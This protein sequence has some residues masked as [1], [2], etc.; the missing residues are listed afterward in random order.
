MDV[1]VT[2]NA[3]ANTA[4]Q[5]VKAGG[6]EGVNTT[7]NAAPSATAQQ[8]Q[9]AATAAK[10]QLTPQTQ[11]RAQVTEQVTV[12]INKAINDGMDQIRIQLKPAHLGRVDVSLEMSQD[13]RISA[14]VSAENKDT[15]DLLKQ[16]SRELE[17]AMREAGLELNS[18]DLSFN[19]RGEGGNNGAEDETAQGSNG[20]Q[21]VEPTLDELL[22][23]NSGHQDIITD[24]RVDIRA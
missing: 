3:N 1:K 7:Q 10:P 17:R 19:L 18:G 20:Q 15:L 16:D 23:A 13:G 22:E 14:V 12:Q 2:Q 5:A 8:T 9:Q 24:D 4:T 21:I 11:A 6:G